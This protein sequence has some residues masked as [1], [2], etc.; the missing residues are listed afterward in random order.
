MGIDCDGD[1]VM[2]VK[3]KTKSP[4]KKTVVTKLVVTPVITQVAI[5]SGLS[6]D[7]S[8]DKV[9]W[10]KTR[11]FERGPKGNKEKCHVLHPYIKSELI[12]ER[13]NSVVTRS[14]WTETYRAV[15]T[16]L[17]PAVVCRI[18]IWDSRNK[19]WIAREGGA[20][21]PEKSLKEDVERFRGSYMSVVTTKAFRAAAVRFGI[22]VDSR[23]LG[24][25]LAGN[26]RTDP[27]PPEYNVVEFKIEAVSTMSKGPV[28][29]DAWCFA[30][31]LSE[32][33]EL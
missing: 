9:T 11:T 13:L 20:L 25:V 30:P 18:G 22:G 19:E 8:D 4:P 12:E 27:P 31:K 10:M 3:K 33:R 7:F 26:V 1:G 29:V 16:P 6:R 17:G 15:S 24:E 32:L 5:W 2:V 21:Y 23:S 14:G 28:E